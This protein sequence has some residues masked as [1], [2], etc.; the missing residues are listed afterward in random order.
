[1]RITPSALPASRF[2]ELELA[3]CQRCNRWQN[4][5]G[6]WLF[7]TVSRLGDGAFWLLQIPLLLF[8]EPAAPDGVLHLLAVAAVS[9][10][11][12]KTIKK[13]TARDRPYTRG[14]GIELLSAPLDRYS[15]PSGHTLHAV[16]FSLVIVYYQ[17]QLFWLVVPF[18]ALVAMSR[19][20]LGLHYP[21]DVVAGAGLG[22]AIALGSFQF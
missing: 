11:T 10:V 4:R 3:L 21:T 1:M 6:L 13:L 8:L 2:F 14:A 15:F 19:V 20:V 9:C 7:R 12:Y 5:P 17:P 18:T 16:A 22:A